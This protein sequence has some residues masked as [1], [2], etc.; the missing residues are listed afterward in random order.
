MR[1]VF[2]DLETDSRDVETAQIIQIGAIA[3][4][5]QLRT[6]EM[7]ESK[8][9]FDRGRADPQSLEMNS[10]DDA[11]WAAEQVPLSVTLDEFAVFARQ[12]ADVTMISKKGRPFKVAQLIGHN[13]Q[14]FDGPIIQRVYKQR[15]LFLPASFA[16]MDT[17]QRAKFYFWERW[18]D[19]QQPENFKLGTLAEVFGVK[20]DDAHDALA[21]CKAT[22]D[23]YR[24]MLGIE[25]IEVGTAKE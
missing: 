20:L 13:A 23:V 16:V 5:E 8:V 17:C 7:F 19:L 21:D 6:L 22:R 24:A 12:Y 4:D 1:L 2:F 10:Y 3:V 9:D 25:E 11:V 18:A 15:D 14:T